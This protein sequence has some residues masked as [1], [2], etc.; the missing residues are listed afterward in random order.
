[1]APFP[2]MTQSWAATARVVAWLPRG[3]TLPRE[4][5]RKRH[6]GLRWLLWAHIPALVGLDAVL[7][8]HDRYPTSLLLIPVAALGAAGGWDAVPRRAQSAAVS[9]GL[10]AS[11]ALAVYVTEGVTEAHF[12]FFV[13]VIALSL[14]EDWLI[15]GLAIGFV[16]LHHGLA[17]AIGLGHVYH[18]AGNTWP[19]AGLHGAFVLAAAAVCVVSWRLSEQVRAELMVAER[20]TLESRMRE[21]QKLESLGLLAGGVAHDFNNL[22]TGVMGNAGLALA[23]LPEQSPLRKYLDGIE[24]AA[25]RST[26]L[27]K[28]MLAYAGNGNLAFDEVD[29]SRLVREMTRLLDAGISKQAVLEL[30]LG[31]AVGAV[32]GDAGQLSQVVMNLITNAA[33]SLEGERGTIVVRTAP[34]TTG[35]LAELGPS[36]LDPTQPYV[37]IEVADTG[38]GMDDDTRHRLF[39]PFFTTKFAGRGLGLAAVSGIVRS[40]GGHIRVSSH[41]GHG[42]TFRVFLPSSALK[43]EATPRVPLAKSRHHCGL[44]LVVDDEPMVRE[45]ASAA[46]RN[47]GF[48]VISAGS[49]VEAIE[50]LNG[51][52][53]LVCVALVDMTM[54]GLNGLETT[55]ALRKIQ[56]NLQLILSSGYNPDS[57]DSATSEDIAF[58][59]KPYDLVQLVQMV[60]EAAVT[61]VGPARAA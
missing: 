43:L 13:L 11:A 31:D 29:V 12:L 52:M 58:L 33:E 45:V 34:A 26:A 49:G 25:M 4:T 27:T 41:V 20:A 21:A 6:A 1:M 30:R 24:L 23:L 18:H 19:W 48:E 57:I 10:L 44:V 22:L 36:G 7:G 38:V 35:E 54:P 39:E 50:C 47:A 2:G 9:V 59:Q 51:A 53:S 5:W 16:V 55:R 40:H 15:F 37:L 8:Q 56:P 61:I 42:S 17:S 32:R 14:Y 46:L 3:H 28:Q 60:G